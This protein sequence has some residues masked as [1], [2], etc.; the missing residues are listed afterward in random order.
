LDEATS[1]LDSISETKIQFAMKELLQS[2][3]TMICIAHRLSTVASMNRIIVL[4][5][6][7]I[8]EQGKH[9]E[10]IQ[11]NGLYAELWNKQLSFKDEEEVDTSSNDEQETADCEVDY[12]KQ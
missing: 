2:N 4:E 11:M 1:S 6:G 12:T 8:I 9:Y 3:D 10:L 7:K 5:N